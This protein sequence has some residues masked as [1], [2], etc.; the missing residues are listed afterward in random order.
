MQFKESDLPGIGK[1]FT[2]KTNAGHFIS[3]ILHINGKREIFHFTDPDDDPIFHFLMTEEEA[4]LIGSVLMG[5]YF[6]PEQDKQ[7]E[8]LLNKLSI[9]WIDVHSNSSLINHSILQLQVRKLTGITIIAIIRGNETIINPKPETVILP[10]DTL[11]IA[12]TREQTHN[13]AQKFNLDA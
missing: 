5:T 10:S 2:I 7:K 11:I 1:K 9:E 13:F 6:K 8:L 3:I 12:G 4:N